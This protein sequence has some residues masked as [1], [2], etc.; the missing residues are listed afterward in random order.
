MRI[1]E[2]AAI[3]IVLLA[4]YIYIETLPG[5]EQASI[6]RA[7]AHKMMIID[8]RDSAQAVEGEID[9]E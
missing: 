3:I 9:R 2:A 7:I 5:D 6:K 8:K 1:F 4:A